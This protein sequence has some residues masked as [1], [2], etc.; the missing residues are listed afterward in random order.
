V[1]ICRD[2]HN[3]HHDHACVFDEKGRGAQTLIKADKDRC[4]LFECDW[5]DLSMNLEGF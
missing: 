5:E 4:S 1:Y 2:R 3:K